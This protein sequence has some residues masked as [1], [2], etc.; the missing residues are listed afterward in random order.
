LAFKQLKGK[1]SFDKLPNVPN[2]SRDGRISTK[3]RDLM[4][5]F[6]LELVAGNFYEAEYDDYVPILQ[7]QLGGPPKIN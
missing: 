2:T 7:E 6:N 1:Q 5:E 3:T 4:A